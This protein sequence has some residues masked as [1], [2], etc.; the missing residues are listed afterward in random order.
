MSDQFILPFLLF[1]LIFP[2]LLKLFCRFLDLF[3]LLCGLLSLELVLLLDLE[4]HL[5]LSLLVSL[6]GYSLPPGVVVVDFTEALE[7]TAKVLNLERFKI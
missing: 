6:R 7:N 5:G 4:E 3:S 1:S 2:L